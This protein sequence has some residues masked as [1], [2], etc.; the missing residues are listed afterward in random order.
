MRPALTP[1]LAAAAAA[2]AALPWGAAAETK[3]PG[4]W[5]MKTEAQAP[6]G[7]WRRSLAAR[8]QC[9]CFCARVKFNSLLSLRTRMARS[10]V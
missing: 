7:A 9:R 6:R 8:R 10:K 5:K 1:H 2:A 3:I 4:A